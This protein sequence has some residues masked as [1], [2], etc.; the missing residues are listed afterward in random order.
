MHKSS[1]FCLFV[2]LFKQS[3]TFLLSDFY[4]YFSARK[5]KLTNEELTPP[6]LNTQTT[7][8]LI[9]GR[10]V[11]FKHKLCVRLNTSYMVQLIILLKCVVHQWRSAA[12]TF[13]CL[14]QTSGFCSRP[15]PSV[16]DMAQS[17]PAMLDIFHLRQSPETWEIFDQPSR[18]QRSRP[19]SWVKRKIKREENIVEIGKK[20]SSH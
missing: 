11:F 13:C 8:G 17:Q 2:C 16:I 7:A 14:L 20:I 10:H 15:F 1:L 3:F 4:F 5:G 9:S 12:V 18:D 19:R 6:A